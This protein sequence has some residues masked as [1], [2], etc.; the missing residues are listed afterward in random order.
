[1][2]ENAEI[3]G[4]WKGEY[5]YDDKFQPTIV[6]TSIPFVL[7]I[8]SIDESGVFEGICQ[9]DPDS[10]RIILPANIYG[11]IKKKDIYFTKKYSK[12]LI[13]DRLGNVVTGDEPHP[14]IIYSGTLKDN[15]QF[16][17]AWNIQRTFRKIDSKVTELIALSGI[18][19]MKRF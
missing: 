11:V 1:M 15:E 18:W 13:G 5:V 8:K 4:I 12:T 16:Y 7:R 9:D 2:T 19:W 3:K 14:D 17:G 10:S 6:K